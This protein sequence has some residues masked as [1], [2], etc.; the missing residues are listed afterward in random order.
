M[1]NA[2]R[3]LNERERVQAILQSGETERLHAVPHHGSYNVGFHS[4]GVATIITLL[5]PDPSAS[6]LKAA[7]LHDSAEKYSGDLPSS[8]KWMGINGVR[9]KMYKA[10]V[11]DEVNDALGINDIIGF[12]GLTA[13]EAN[14]LHGA[15]MLEFLVWCRRKLNMGNQNV[16]HVSRNAFNA[17][18]E[19]WKAGVVPEAIYDAAIYLTGA[20]TSELHSFGAQA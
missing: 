16:V 2:L 4:W 11:E 12:G 8:I 13:D 5:N 10:R 18:E 9:A 20:Q 19:N 6:L 7:L 3:S 15:D 17:L 1:T 14:W